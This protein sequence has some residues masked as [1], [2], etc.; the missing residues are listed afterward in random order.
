MESV[1]SISKP[2]LKPA[3]VVEVEVGEFE[4]ALKVHSHS[5][6]QGDNC[7]NNGTDCRAICN[8]GK[9]ALRHFQRKNDAVLLSRRARSIHGSCSSGCHDFREEESER[10]GYRNC[11][12]M[13][14]RACRYHVRS[15]VVLPFVSGKRWI[16]SRDEG[17]GRG[18]RLVE[19]LGENGVTVVGGHLDKVIFGC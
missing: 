9:M 2:G 3:L 4:K 6:E 10:L 16:D 7:P 8:G 18:A 11:W 19:R 14:A 17:S 5:G 12:R 15:V 13:V 1:N